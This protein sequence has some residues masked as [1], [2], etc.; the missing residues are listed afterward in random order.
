LNGAAPGSTS[1]PPGIIYAYTERSRLSADHEFANIS[2]DITSK[3]NVEAGE[4]HFH[5]SFRY[6]DPYQQ[7]AYAPT[8]P[9]LT[10]G[11]SHKWDSKFGINYKLLDHLMVYA[12]FA[13]GFRDGGSN[14]GYPSILLRE[15]R[16]PAY[17][18]DTLNNY[19]LGWKS[20]LLDN[21]LTWDG[22]TYLMHWKQLQTIIYDADICA[23]SSFNAN[24]GN[25]T[26]LRHGIERRLQ[27]HRQLVDAGVGQLHRFTPGLDVNTRR[28]EGNVG[29]RL[30]YVHP[31]SAGARTC[32]TSTR[33]W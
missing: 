1:L 14:S 22:A 17:V 33:S 19:E 5:S 15:G 27:D 25:A 9:S 31:T 12:D 7:F 21:H 28:F 32:G 30:P 29:E 11:G 13:Q 10:V 23:P 8:T 2:F 3:L 18:P 16:D 20:T 6:S 26:H 24:V 4:S